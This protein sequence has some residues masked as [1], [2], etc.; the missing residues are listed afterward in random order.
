[1]KKSKIGIDAGGSLIKLCYEQKGKLHFKKY[2][3]TQVESAIEW[4]KFLAPHSQVRLTG[5]KAGVI[6]QTFLPEARI[7]PEFTATCE[8][9]Q[10]LNKQSTLPIK[11]P[12]LLVNIGTGTSWFLINGDHYERVLGSGMGGGTFVGLGNVI[13]NERDFFKLNQLSSLGNKN[14]VDLLVKDIY[15]PLEP[16]INGDLTASNFGKVADIK[17]EDG[18]A[19]LSNLMAETLILLTMQTAKLHKVNEIVYIGNTLIGNSL[20]KTTLESYTTALGFSAYFL[21]N[22]EFSGAVGAF[23]AD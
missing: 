9:A 3:Y 11:G 14:N 10:F 16:P 12:F 4:L 6:Q 7:I 1:M 23:M 13:S 2:D 5:G 21:E 8:G 19:A 20:L 22:G 15:H 17:P 18:I